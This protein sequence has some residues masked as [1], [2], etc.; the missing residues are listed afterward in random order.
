MRKLLFIGLFAFAFILLAFS[1]LLWR[2]PSFRDAVSSLL[3]AN[4]ELPQALPFAEFE[5]EDAVEETEEVV[6]EAPKED[7]RGEMNLAVPFTSQAPN[8][9]W[10]MPWQEA[11]EE[12]AL[13]MVAHFKQGENIGSRDDATN[14]I[15]ALVSWEEETLG[16]YQDTTAEEIA[17]TAREYYG[18]SKTR[19]VYEF[20]AQDIKNE[21]AQGNPVIIPSAGRMLPNP[22]FRS[23]GP[24]YHAIVVRGWLKDGRFITNDPGTKRGEEFLYWPDDI[25]FAAHDWNS[26]DVEHGRRAMIVVE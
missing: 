11:C 24:L 5:E 8:A 12:A 6:V 25:V 4:N 17:R 9:D 21:I 7:E 15:L 19:V 26:G 10:N 13:L 20:S 22:Y 1:L 16:Y 23:P 2:A 14:K 18:F 3:Q